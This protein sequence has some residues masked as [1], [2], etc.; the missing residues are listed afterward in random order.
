MATLAFLTEESYTLL[1]SLTMIRPLS[2]L[3]VSLSV[4][5]LCYV[6]SGNLLLVP[7]TLSLLPESFPH[8][9]F[10]KHIFILQLLDYW[11]V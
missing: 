1:F 5:A 8:I 4:L 3:P 10:S 7:S 11:V 9:L 2:A 6:S